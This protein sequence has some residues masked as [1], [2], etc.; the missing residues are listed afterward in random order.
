MGSIGTRTEKRSTQMSV[1][2]AG[3]K[4]SK[5]KVSGSMGAFSQSLFESHYASVLGGTEKVWLKE[6]PQ[7]MRV[8]AQSPPFVLNQAFPSARVLMRIANENL[9]RFIGITLPTLDESSEAY[10]M[11][12][13]MAKNSLAYIVG[14]EA[15]ELNEDFKSS[16]IRDIV[17]G[18]SQLQGTPIGSHGFLHAHNV[19]VDSRFT[20]SLTDYGIP[21]AHEESE[22]IALTIQMVHNLD[23]DV[24]MKMFYR[25][26]E[27]LR[28]GLPPHGTK[29]G[30]IY[31]L[32]MLFAQVWT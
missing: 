11:F 10:V 8:V 18:I 16:L 3:T 6:F 1:T 23:D 19:V 14:N 32:G 21:F 22:Y 17:A 9:A 29:K 2:T 24:L 30:D 13:F 5:S 12:R 15:V 7:P 27:L 25:G 31:S 20:A 4:G 26:P 28:G